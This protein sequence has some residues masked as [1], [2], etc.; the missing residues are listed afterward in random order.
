MTMTKSMRSLWLVVAACLGGIS[1]AGQGTQRA[2]PDVRLMT[3]DPG[4]FHAGLVQK[5][6]YPGVSARVD[7]AQGMPALRNSS[8]MAGLS[9]HR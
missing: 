1:A 7:W 4:H 2:M 5:E 8:F 6:M 9:R 3:V